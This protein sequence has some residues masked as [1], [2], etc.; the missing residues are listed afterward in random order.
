MA[1]CAQDHDRWRTSLLV[2]GREIWP[3]PGNPS[4][5]RFELHLGPSTK[6]GAEIDY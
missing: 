2:P 4:M 1:T 6:T 5:G 3:I